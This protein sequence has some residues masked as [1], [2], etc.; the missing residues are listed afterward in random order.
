MKPCRLKPDLLPAQAL[1]RSNFVPDFGVMLSVGLA[2]T[3]SEEL[4]ALPAELSAWAAR[5]KPCSLAKQFY[6][7]NG[8]SAE[9]K[10]SVGRLTDFVVIRAQTVDDHNG[11]KILNRHGCKRFRSQLGPGKHRVAFD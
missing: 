6:P 8:C 2:E 1:F 10:F 7:A 3:L 9:R 4:H 5:K 11:R